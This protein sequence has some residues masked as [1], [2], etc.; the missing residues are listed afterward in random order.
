[1]SSDKIFFS[2]SRFDSVFVLKLASDLRAAGAIVW[3]DQLDIPPGK[4]WDSEIED[5]LKNANCLLAILS[6]KSLESDNV[7]DE[8]SFALEE[9]K[10]VIPILLTDPGTPFRLRR[11]QRVDFTGD[12]ETGFNQLLKSIN[13]SV[14]AMPVTPEILPVVNPTGETDTIANLVQ[15][16]EDYMWE[17]CC[18]LNT[19]P[20]YQDYLR[21][22]ALRQHVDEAWSKITS[23]EQEVGV[24]TRHAFAGKSNTVQGQKKYLLIAASVIGLLGLA[25]GA[26]KIFSPK[27]DAIVTT[28]NMDSTAPSKHGSLVQQADSGLAIKENEQASDNESV[29]TGATKPTITSEVQSPKPIVVTSK[30]IKDKTQEPTQHPRGSSAADSTPDFNIQVQVPPEAATPPPAPAPTQIRLA[31]RVVV[32]L[33][34]LDAVDMNQKKKSAQKVRFTVTSPVQYQGHTL[35]R[36]GSTAYG[37]ITVGS[38]LTDLTIYEVMGANGKMLPLKSEHDR[39]KVKDIETNKNFTAILKEGTYTF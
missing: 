15:E 25:W 28:S 26:Y 21:K 16:K 5:A 31:S 36:Q 38:R 24:Q 33:S 18:Y 23:L 4:H 35:I 2:Y 3:L 17:R 1:M 22:T 10:K 7:M 9:K 14:K 34:L 12:Y 30:K 39:G 20:A 37:T 32:Y 11:L 27:T 13:I 19:I 6:P 29:A 8:I